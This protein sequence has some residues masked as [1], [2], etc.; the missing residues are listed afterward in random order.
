MMR[1]L[2]ERLYFGMLSLTIIGSMWIVKH[3]P[4]RL[5]FFC[6]EGLANLGFYL[7]HSFRKRSLRNLSLALGDQLDRRERARVIQKSL[8]NF[9]RD[10]V[11][12]GYS[13][14]VPPQELR[15]EIAVVGWEHLEVALAKGKGV[16]A[17]SAHLGNFFLVGT[18]LALE[19]YPTYVLVNPPRNGSF[20]E[21]LA[22]YRLKA[23]QRTIHSR[24]RQQASQELLRVLRQNELA[25]LI[26][27]EYRAGRGIYVPF[28]GRTVIA[29]R[30]PATLAL[31]TGAALVPVYLIRDRN[32]RLT[33]IIEPEIEIL[34]SGNINAD[35]M[36]STLRVTQWLE[37][38]VRSYP[39]QWNWMN[40]RWQEASLSAATGKE[41]RYER[42]A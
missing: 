34:R 25:V 26:A 5:V 8:R 3:A 18:R 10:F 17:L 32:G 23:G 9:F 24:P 42:F 6:S 38:A 39:D 12:I 37:R 15:R 2:L 14:S 31:R 29:R 16:I 20:K 36:E 7:F 40:I 11:E 22:H 4:R 21:L 35:I 33:L 41:N 27:D 1:W 19:G 13:L 30:G 28:F